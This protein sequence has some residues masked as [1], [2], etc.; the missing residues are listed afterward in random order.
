[1]FKLDSKHPISN[2]PSASLSNPEP[3]RRLIVLVPALEINLTALAQKVWELAHTS[4]SQVLFLGLYDDAAQESRLRRDLVTI[5]AMVK[6]DRVTAKVEVLFGKDWVNVVRTHWHSGDMVVCFAEQR[7]GSSQ[8]LLSQALQAELNIQLYI[9]S[10]L[11]PRKESHINWLSQVAIW[12]GS[13]AIIFGFFTLQ[14]KL[15]Q[16]TT[17]WTHTILLLISIPVEVGLIWIWNSLF[18]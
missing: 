9:L 6:D 3:A 11:Y 12:G 5:S 8:Q 4:E 17:D 15:D 10:G 13:I 18:G 16:L 14:I 1:M 2:S 7:I